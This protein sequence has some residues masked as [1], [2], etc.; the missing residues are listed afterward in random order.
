MKVAD[1][2]EKYLALISNRNMFNKFTEEEQ[3]PIYEL[4]AEILIKYGLPGSFYF[5]N[6]L[7]KN[8]VNEDDS[9]VTV[10]YFMEFIAIIAADYLSSSPKTNREILEHAKEHKLS[11]DNVLMYMDIIT[12]M[13]CVF[14]YEQLYMRNIITIDEALYA[15]EYYKAYESSIN[16][17][18]IYTDDFEV[19]IN[20]DKFFELKN[21]GAPYIEEYLKHEIDIRLKTEADDKDFYTIAFNVK[22]WRKSIEVNIFYI[23]KIEINEED[24]N[25][26]FVDILYQNAIKNW[27]AA[28]IICDRPIL[29]L[30]FDNSRFA[31]YA[32]LLRSN[33]EQGVLYMN[34]RKHFKMKH[35]EVI[36]LTMKLKKETGNDF[37]ILQQVKIINPHYDINQIKGSV[38]IYNDLP[39]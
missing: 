39:F 34:L 16:P 6:L 5:S 9:A 4:E 31:I 29:E 32:S 36:G 30:F 20:F 22:K 13:Y 21:N 7:Q 23:I 25:E 24:S 19:K 38:D 18:L 10:E 3:D 28:T 1:K 27:L 26:C 12:H 35:L 14:V 2:I 17:T 8:A 15:L 33:I 11:C 37:Y